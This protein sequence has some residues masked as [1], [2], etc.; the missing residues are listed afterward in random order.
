MGFLFGFLCGVLFIPL[1]LALG[2]Y[3]FFTY[4]ESYA[5]KRQEQL[6]QEIQKEKCEQLDLDDIPSALYASYLGQR[7]G[8][9]AGYVPEHLDPQYQFAGWISVK[10]I[11]DVDHRIIEPSLK[12]E[13]RKIPK[14]TNGSNGTRK[15]SH[16]DGEERPVGSG[17]AGSFGAGAASQDPR[18][19][20]LDTQ[21]PHLSLPPCLQARFKDSK[22]AVIK[23]ATMFIY[24][25]DLMEECLGVIT[26][27][28]YKISVPGQQ[29]DS[30]IFAKRNPIWLEY[31]G[32]NHSRRSTAG[33]DGS[34]PSSK[35]YYLSMVSC[36]DKEDLYFTLLRCAKLKPNNGRSFI[37]EIPKRDSTLFDKTAMNTLIRTIHS[38]EHQFQAAWLNALLGRMFLGI[39]KTPQVKE[40]VLQKMV[41]KLTRLRLPNFLNDMRMKSV[42]LGDGVPLITRPKL[43]TLK[44]NGDMI[45]DM[46][47]L[48]QGGF[49]AEVEA[50]AV[51]TVTKKIQPIKVSLVLMMALLRLEGRVQVWIKPPPCNRIWYGFYHKPQ[52]EMKIEP[53]VSDKHIKSNLIIKA[54]ENKMLE[55][56]AETMV[57]PNMDDIPFSDSDGIG[58]VFGEEISPGGETASASIPGKQAQAP[59]R[60]SHSP[61]R[62]STINVLDS[63]GAPRSAIDLGSDARN[64]TETLSANGVYQNMSG[65]RSHVSLGDEL[66]QT[67][68]TYDSKHG[69]MNPLDEDPMRSLR[70]GDP[71]TESPDEI[72]GPGRHGEVEGDFMAHK[73]ETLP[74]NSNSSVGSK[75][76]HRKG[77]NTTTH[78]N[79]R[80]SQDPAFTS[81]ASLPRFSS[82]PPFPGD[83]RT[84][85]WSTYGMSEY[86]PVALEGKSGKNKEK[87]N[88]KV[89]KKQDKENHPPSVEVDHISIDSRDSGDTGS[90]KAGPGSIYGISIAEGSVYSTSAK[91]DKFSLSKMFQGF[92]KKHTKG[93]HSGSS[94]QLPNSST[95][96]LGRYGPGHP[97]GDPTDPYS[98]VMEDDEGSTRSDRLPYSQT[99]DGRSTTTSATGHLSTAYLPQFKQKFESTPNLSSLSGYSEREDTHAQETAP[100]PESLGQRSIHEEFEF[101]PEQVGGSPVGSVYAASLFEGSGSDSNGN[102]PRSPPNSNMAHHHLLNFSPKF[103]TAI[104]KLRRPHGS[105]SSREELS[106]PSGDITAYLNQQNL[107]LQQ[108]EENRASFEF[109]ATSHRG[110]SMEDEQFPRNVNGSF[111]SGGANFQ[112]EIVTSRSKSVQMSAAPMIVLQKASP[113]LT[114]GDTSSPVYTE[115]ALLSDNHRAGSPRYLPEHQPLSQQPQ[116]T[117]TMRKDHR[118]LSSNGVVGLGATAPKPRRHSINHPPSIASSISGQF[119]SQFPH[120]LGMSAVPA[121]PL[122]KEF[123]P[124]EDDTSA[125]PPP[126]PPSAQTT[127]PSETSSTGNRTR[128]NSE[129]LSMSST[130]SSMTSNSRDSHAHSST[131]RNILSSLGNKHKKKQAGY[132]APLPA[133]IP[134]AA[135]PLPPTNDA[136]K[137]QVIQN[138]VN[139]VSVGVV[140]VSCSA[141]AVES[142]PYSVVGCV[143]GIESHLALHPSEDEMRS[144]HMPKDVKKDIET[145]TDI[146]ATTSPEELKP[147]EFSLLTGAK[148]LKT[149][150]KEVMHARP[151]Y[152]G[153]YPTPVRMHSFLN[154]EG[155]AIRDEEEKAEKR[156]SW[157]G[158]STI[159][160]TLAGQGVFEANSERERNNSL[161]LPDKASVLPGPLPVPCGGEVIPSGVPILVNTPSSESSTLYTMVFDPSKESSAAASVD[162]R[163]GDTPRTGSGGGAVMSRSEYDAMMENHKA[164]QGHQ[165]VATDCCE[166]NGS[167]GT[168][169][170]EQPYQ[171]EFQAQ[172]Q[173]Q[174][175]QQQ[176][177]QKFV[178]NPSVQ[179]LAPEQ[180]FEQAQMLDP[181][182]D[183]DNDHNMYLQPASPQTPTTPK[184]H[185]NIFKRLIRRKSEDAL[186][187]GHHHNNHLPLSPSSIY[188]NAG[189]AQSQ[190]S[191]T[192]SGSAFSIPLFHRHQEHGQ[193]Q[194]G[195]GLTN[196]LVDGY[197]TS[198]PSDVGKVG[199]HTRARTQSTASPVVQ[200]QGG[201]S[202]LSVPKGRPRSST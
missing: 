41:E 157:Q 162:T 59:P 60:R 79:R 17:V 149:G 133:P 146:L 195:Q 32:S 1:C 198:A 136:P 18:F 20:Y 148:P 58:G 107:H 145:T 197:E 132:E 153:E 67:N 183:V 109:D 119:Q 196:Y 82:A 178:E 38:N 182:N 187:Q 189:L 97:E 48:Y 100:Q 116:E 169:V 155:K 166:P 81:G 84:E 55:A 120:G 188:L 83:A 7:S 71:L 44:P 104:R 46:N 108:R 69:L 85:E 2:V 134:V 39:Y 123:S 26:I 77:G 13:T 8:G 126:P 185:R 158:G 168:L 194:Q 163:D 53:V 167:V 86:E 51:V 147:G 138:T 199:E 101:V 98:I 88:K 31:H 80:T 52:V 192:T 56:I 186:G 19:T 160:E 12:K 161:P 131:L 99:D 122:R 92:R 179:G 154:R 28:N 21:N 129:T 124:S 111:I 152:I 127:L 24:E 193:D 110:T 74:A 172:Q 130:S 66:M 68:Y 143:G 142:D 94:I 22:Y 72:F 50:E 106:I 117:T 36:I 190:S 45:M 35:D 137:V 63:P 90:T 40:M 87:A 201:F 96:I 61:G 5:E 139:M 4:S 184:K 141:V 15:S 89:D 49:R 3:W 47:L 65:S 200:E 175:Q 93:A 42:H 105:G 173:L 112:P 62:A 23:G 27:P 57:L 170:I 121:S 176:Q 144:W 115:G 164:C 151:G 150:K 177:Q 73:S 25:N 91:S 75:L 37:R 125:P 70:S 135:A 14:S 181:N 34:Q 43:L 202:R 128:T 103:G 54:I 140:A 33:S 191:V 9:L 29:K 165:P 78:H 174:Q 95:E 10:R 180:P 11:P 113:Y 76:F 156:K 64:R 118:P 114:Q 102:N 159:G 30:H 6:E 171:Q 16:G